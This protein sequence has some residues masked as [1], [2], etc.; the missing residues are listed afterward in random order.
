[1]SALSRIDG[2]DIKLCGVSVVGA[3]SLYGD[4]RVLSR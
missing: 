2:S 3:L 4:A 1:M